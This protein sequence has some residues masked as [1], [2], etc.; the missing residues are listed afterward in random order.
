[1][2]DLTDDDLSVAADM[3][4]L[5]QVLVNLI[6]NACDVLE[7]QALK[8]IEVSAAREGPSV[9]LQVRDS[10]PGIAARD[11]ERVFDPFFTTTEGGLG[12]GLS[13]S[14]TIA[15]RLGGSLT[16]GNVRGG[17]AVFTLTL[18]AWRDENP[19]KLGSQQ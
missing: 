19:S 9:R 13:I 6:G 2:V 7:G 1:M 4:Q 12:L 3:V 10:G 5:E 8:R 18:A 14:H 17:G 16:A 15:R 11:L